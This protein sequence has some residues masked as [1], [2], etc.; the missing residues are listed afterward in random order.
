MNR[1]H[2][3][4]TPEGGCDSSVD[5]LLH[6][7]R[8]SELLTQACV[9]LIERAN[10]HDDSKLLSPEKELFDELTPRLKGLTYNSPEYK[11]SLAEL[12]VALKHHYA[13][14]SHHPQ[15]YANG[16]DGMNLFDILEMFFDWKAASERHNDGNINLSISENR[17]RFKLSDQLT[18]I[19]KN[20]V[21]YLGW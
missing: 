16:V 1:Y 11:E 14:N 6:I 18:N 15:H 9:E 2:I 13:H 8:V 19:F 17:E 7:K 20:T 4:T 12:Q 3:P 21:Q 10:K 5:T